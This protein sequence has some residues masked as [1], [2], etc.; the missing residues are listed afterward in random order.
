M[1]I[2]ELLID[3][4]LTGVS[5]K[6]RL[7]HGPSHPLRTVA[8]KSFFVVQTENASSARGKE[9]FSGGGSL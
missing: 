7:G 1:A 5:A 4:H 9:D 3:V 6:Y 8:T 2:V